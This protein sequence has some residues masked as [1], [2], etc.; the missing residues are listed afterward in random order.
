MQAKAALG[1]A[2]HVS[3]LRLFHADTR[4]NIADCVYCYA[5]QS[6]LPTHPTIKYG[7]D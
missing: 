5:A 6:G 2:Q 7:I 3:T 4:Q 1:D